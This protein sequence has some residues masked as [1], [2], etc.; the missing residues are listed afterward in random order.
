MTISVGALSVFGCSSGGSGTPIGGTAGNSGGSAGATTA[1]AAG[2][3]GGS[4]GASTGGSA[5]SQGGGS[6]GASTGGSA[7]AST[8]GAAGAGTAGMSGGAGA[9]VVA[10]DGGTMTGTAGSGGRPSGPSAACGK[11]APT[12]PIGKAVMHNLMVT[13]IASK[14]MPAYVSR[15]YYT[16]LPTMFDPTKQYPVVFYG[17]GCGQTGSEGSSWTSGHFLTDVFYVQLIPAT[18]T[19]ATVVPSD[20]SPGCFQA[21]KQGGADSPDGPYFDQVLA[22]IEQTYCID[23]GKLYVSGSS[24]GAWLSNYLACARGNV[25]RGAT[26]DSGG[27]QH[28]HG[29][30]TG[31]AAI[32]E[33]P[34]DST[35]SIVGGFDIGV[36][37]ARDTF[38]AANGCSTTPTSTMAFGNANGC[39]VYGNCTSPVVWCNVGGG[40]QS[41]QGFIA[42]SSWAF[43]MTLQ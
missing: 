20:G 8:G 38:I 26:A 29:T 31:G 1:G 16:T 2:D 22:Q 14:Y 36:G 7:G 11:D 10:P 23:T 28:D 6:A 42:D 9:T 4:A 30:C 17:Q 18:V 21:G 34:G 5:G 3:S 33:M 41:G 25:L 43:W 19:G 39:M 32:M 12:D 15:Y 24:S 13:N 40:H 27:L 35:S 37:P